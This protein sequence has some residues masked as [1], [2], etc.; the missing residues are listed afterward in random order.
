MTQNLR[1]DTTDAVLRQPIKE[2]TPRKKP[3]LRLV[4]GS[5]Y[6]TKNT[7]EWVEGTEVDWGPPGRDDREGYKECTTLSSFR[8]RFPESCHVYDLQVEVK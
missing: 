7:S 6:V 4:D 5:R 3:T 8:G 2:T 1:D